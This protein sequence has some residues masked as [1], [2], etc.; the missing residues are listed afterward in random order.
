MIQN[1]TD[2]TTEITN[3]MGATVGSTFFTTEKIKTTAIDA[4]NWATS[5]YQW[6]QLET[7]KITPTV[8]TQ[9]YYDYPE[10][11]Q[12]DSVSR[13]IVGE[14]LYAIKNFDD[15]LNYKYF[16]KGDENIASDYGQQIFL[17]PTP[18]TNGTDIIIFGLKMADALVNY[19]DETIFTHEGVVGN[20]A[21]VK[22][23]VGVLLAQANRKQEGQVE[24]AEA[25]SLLANLYAKIIKRQAKYQRLDKQMFEVPDFFAPNKTEDIIG[26]F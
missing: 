2:I 26:N 12:V 5:L 23:A 1:L 20:E 6:P 14:D 21:V 8:A 11:F 22:K 15:F 19:E 7:A 16:T 10:G 25:I 17:Y 9:Y 13:V 18:T 24:D 4:Y 3:R